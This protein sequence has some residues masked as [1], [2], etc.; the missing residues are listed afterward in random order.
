MSQNARLLDRIAI[1][2]PCG[3][4][5]DSMTGDDRTRHCAECKLDV[6]NLA[7]MTA[8]EAEALLRRKLGEGR[9]CAQ[10][11]RRA[12]GTVL[13]A[14]CPRGLRAARRRLARAIGRAGAIFLLSAGSLGLT[15]CD[16]RQVLLRDSRARQL[17]V[18]GR[19]LDWIDPPPP[20]AISGK[21]AIRGDVVCPT[22]VTVP[23]PR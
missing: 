10:V 7:E 1:A 5:W 21:I 11:Y 18:L 23:A 14:D 17:P 22:P 20:P 19:I 9:V 12:D 8:D 2:S 6:Y 4:G 13:T 3:V 16:R 15:G